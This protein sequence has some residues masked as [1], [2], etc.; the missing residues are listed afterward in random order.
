MIRHFLICLCILMLSACVSQPIENGVP[1]TAS[2]EPQSVT[3]MTFN[4]E[5]LFDTTDDPG[6]DDHAYLP[7]VD[8]DNAA[9]VALCEPIE[10]VRWR[11]ECL[12]LDWN[13]AA[14]DFKLGQL[15]ATILQ[16]NG[17]RGPDVI[18]LQEVENIGVLTRLSEDYLQAAGYRHVV[19]LEGR[20]KR[21]IDVAFLSRLPL[22]DDP[23]LHPFNISG[24]PDRAD[25]TRGILQATFVL[26]DQRLLTGFA[27]HFPAP[28]HPIEMRELAYDHLNSLRAQLPKEHFVFAAGDFNTPRRE[29]TG[30]TIMDDRVRPHWQVAHEVGCKDCKG[31][32]YWSR[33]KSW[34]FL[35]MVLFAPSSVNPDAWKIDANEV[36]IANSYSDQMN[37]DGT[38]KRF[39]L[40]NRRGVSDHLPLVMTLVSVNATSG[41]THI[42]ADDVT[43]YAPIRDVVDA[44]TDTYGADDVLVVLDIDNTLM[45]ST[46]DLGGDIWYQ[47]QRGRLDVKPTDEQTVA[48]LFQDAIGMLYELGTMRLTDVSLPTTVA[49][50]QDQGVNVFALTSRAP[51]YR[52]ATER[53]LL[54]LGL[55]LRRTALS[56]M[57]ESAPVLREMDGREWSY[58]HGVMMTSG[59]NKGAMLSKILNRTGRRFSAIVFVDDTR[60]HVDD[61]FAAFQSVPEVDVRIFHFTAIEAARVAAFGAVVTQAQADQMAADWTALNATLDT[62]FPDRAATSGCLGR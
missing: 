1:A 36:F 25:D 2:V 28:F 5:N 18:A 3:I 24:F 7:L 39:D 53:E 30:T 52:A 33:G 12:A 40:S 19:L 62:I 54:R 48:C 27:V 42:I 58:M 38:V 57:G 22:A 50:W 51:K 6:K 55:D 8:K 4:V 49:G 46:A 21:G 47:W 61:V 16:V 10:V 29:M 37:Q 23:V 13:E 14:L 59:M 43:T 11:N 56:A 32:N 15:A 45:T 26:P 31:T 35:D 60:R 34:S 41:T 44:L 17:G 9:H 20:D